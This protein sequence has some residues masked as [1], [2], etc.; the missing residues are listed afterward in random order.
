MKDNKGLY[1]KS[2][3]FQKESN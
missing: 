2:S 3:D 1:C